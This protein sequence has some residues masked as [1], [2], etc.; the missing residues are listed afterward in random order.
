MTGNDDAGQVQISAS[1]PA[2]S[3]WLSANAGSGKTRVLTDRVARLLLQGIDPQSI[4]CLTYTKAAASEMQNRLFKRLG[5]W[6]MLD[7]DSLTQGLAE[8]GEFSVPDLGAARTLFARAIDTP[9]GLKIQT[10]HSFCAALLRQFP[11]EAGVTPQFRELDEIAR[12]RL[13]EDV[14]DRL[15]TETPAALTDIA[16]H[17]SGESLTKLAIQVARSADDFSGVGRSE[18]CAL[19]G[20][21]NDLTGQ[22]IVETAIKPGDLEFL[23]TLPD[24]LRTSTKVSDLSLANKI[25]SLPENASLSVVQALADVL[26]Y[27][28]DARA[29]FTAK[30]E[31]IPTKEFREG[32][33][34]PYTSRFHQI[35]AQVE[36]AFELLRPFYAAEMTQALHGFAAEF[37]PAYA[38]AKDSLG[39]L[40]FDDL[41]LKARG[42]LQ[43]QGLAW[44]LFR[45]DGGINHILVD[46]AQD[47]SPAQWEVIDA[48]AAEITAGKGA[49]EDEPRSFF[50]VGDKKQSIYSF[51]GADARAFDLMAEKFAKQ[52]EYGPKL[53][54]QELTHSFRSSPAIL[55]VVDHVFQEE[56]AAGLGGN[57]THHAFHSQ[58]PGRVDLWP[59]VP[60]P[61]TLEE[62]AWNDPVDRRAAN[63]PSIVLADRIA[64]WIERA[65]DTGT[66]P[67]QNG[68]FRRIVPGDILILVQR[69]AALFDNIIRSCKRLDL[70]IAGA[71]R[72]KVNAELAVRDLLSLLSFLALPEDDLSL[73]T[74]LTS[75]LFGWSEAELFSVSQGRNGYLWSA[76]RDQEHDFPDSVARL[77]TFRNKADFLRP[78]ELIELVLT[79][80]GGRRAL[81]ARLGPEA[82]DGINELLSQSLAYERTE[83]PSLTGFLSR[84]RS[85]DIEIKRQSDT[86]GDL[87]RVMTVHGAKGLESS[88]VLL[89]DTI[90]GSNSRPD[91]FVRSQEGVPLWNVSAA[92]APESIRRAKELSANADAEERQRL[93]YVAMTRAKH[94]L[95]VGGA[96]IE[97]A[98][99]D[100]WYDA[101]AAGLERA[102]AQSAINGDQAIIRFESGDWNLSGLPESRHLET[103]IGDISAFPNEDVLVRDRRPKPRAPSD[104]G[105]HK[106]MPG[107][108][109]GESETAKLRGSQLHLLFEH[110]PILPRSDWKRTA[111]QL[112]DNAASTDVAQ[113]LAEA[114]QCVDA[115]PEVFSDSSLAEVDIAA[116]VP[117]LNSR[118]GGAIDR[119]IIKKERI[120]AIDFK[121]NAVVPTEQEEV[122]EG[123]LRQMGAYLEAL[124][125]I[126]PEREISIEVLWTATGQVMVLEHAIVRSALSRSTTS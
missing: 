30:T 66:V 23:S 57:T 17:F 86:R 115:V 11:L 4:L 13:I 93:L 110:L 44:V 109:G 125:Q 73:A 3:T 41:I 21:E 91:T 104:L 8:L 117:T 43:D 32:P 105:G 5:E 94:W 74:A 112:L 15:A 6:A 69:R 18:I 50:V 26:L 76:L 16:L 68:E 63:D 77:R 101:V 65:L 126:W 1:N 82:E 60:R 48:L 36:D 102:G 58:L 45:L 56:W 81:V 120:R 121:S 83:V 9:G 113:L 34:A 59:K 39:V 27:G 46:E 42:L 7:D 80:F 33:F 70:P 123:I 124:E 40:D 114:T 35:M 64:A 24:I 61:E 20:V 31:N 49:R 53:S 25:S 108:L 54:R 95:I 19:L 29:P 52:L 88:I 55:K 98:P 107:D 67:G 37:N 119:L 97:N 2:T 84:A 103:K 89:P 122:P 71:D 99:R 14:L 106:S 10:I 90:R 75:P 85:E 78:Y 79:R 87:I 96:E 116:H 51:Q 12:D 62:P 47:T 72:L 111:D 38:V 118:I 92:M 28:K 22:E 100:N